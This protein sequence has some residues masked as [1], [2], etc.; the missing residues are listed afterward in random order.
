MSGRR[1]GAPSGRPRAP[2]ADPAAPPAGLF[3]CA[4]C[5][6]VLSTR[7]EF[8]KHQVSW[9]VPGDQDFDAA[10]QPTSQ[11]ASQQMPLTSC[12]CPAQETV[13]QAHNLAQSDEDDYETDEGQLSDTAAA[14][15]AAPAADSS[16]SGGAR[17]PC[18]SSGRG[19]KGGAAAAAAD[20]AAAGIAD[21]HAAEEQHAHG[22]ISTA[23]P[24]AGGRQP[25][26]SKGRPRGKGRQGS[27]ASASEDGHA[28]LGSAAEGQPGGGLQ[29]GDALTAA[30]Q[31]VQELW[32][33]QRKPTPGG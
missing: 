25:R 22:D 4:E 20:A 10:S 27:R 31:A 30:Q 8:K 7:D 28:P 16:S 11:P 9:H 5:G 21:H 33:P 6:E 3:F 12:C 17:A 18:S 1:R 26:S 32:V 15:P 14:A 29:V 23:A 24:A 2:E 13:H 19:R